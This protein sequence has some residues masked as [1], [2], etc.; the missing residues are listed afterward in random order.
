MPQV[1]GQYQTQSEAQLQKLSPLQLMTTR[2]LELSVV[3]LEQRVKDESIEN[4]ALETDRTADSDDMASFDS[5]E[6]STGESADEMDGVDAEKYD[7]M[8]ERM[9]F[10]EDYLDSDDLPAFQQRNDTDKQERPLGETV[11]FVDDLMNQLVD[12][13][14]T[15]HQRELVEYLIGSL[16]DNGYIETPLSRIADEMMF[17]HNIYTD[18]TE[19]E[20]ALSILQQFDPPGIGARDTRECLLLQIDRKMNDKEHL[21]GDKYFLLEDG[22]RIIANYYDLFINNNVEKLK[23]IMNMSSARLRLIFDELKK[24]NL[25]PGLSLTE[26]AKDRVQTAIP[27]FIVETDENGQITVQLNHGDLPKLRVSREYIKRLKT[28]EMTKR[29]L[30]RDEQEFVAYTRPKVDAARLFIEAI[31]QR[32]ETLLRTMKAIAQMQ[33]PFF[34]SQDPNDL[35]PLILKDVAKKAGYDISTVSRVR[36][37]KYCLLDGRMYPLSFFFKH[38]RSN[39][40]G[41]SVDAAKA[42]EA[43]GRLIA[44]EDKTHPLSD[45]QISLLLAKMG[46]NIKRRT[47]AKYRD[48]IGIPPLQHRLSI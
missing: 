24:L 41:E 46:I 29:K 22:R 11:S 39:A 44:A 20:Q 28:Y 8:A 15:D 31:R 25:H 16:N 18:E 47:V 35:K 14:L 6:E 13:D 42:Q 26:S 32:Q 21:L 43:I 30:T 23:A 12:F 34:L 10:M 17:H 19:L 48:E 45:Q 33:Q 37:S 2:L 7:E 40:I 27:D 9:A 3:E 5:S 36:N 4:F 1:Q 38:P